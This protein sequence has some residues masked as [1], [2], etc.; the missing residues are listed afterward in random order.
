V[1]I[2]VAQRRPETGDAA[3]LMRDAD[4]AMYMAKGGGKNRYEVFDARMHD[5]MFGRS[6]L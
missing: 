2:G 1:S 4:F 6:S 3:E 5:N